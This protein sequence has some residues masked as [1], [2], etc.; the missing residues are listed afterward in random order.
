MQGLTRGTTCTHSTYSDLMLSIDN[1]RTHQPEVMSAHLMADAKTWVSCRCNLQRRSFGDHYILEPC[2]QWPIV[3]FT[4][5]NVQGS[6]PLPGPVHDQP[7]CLWY[8]L[9]TEFIEGTVDM[10]VLRIHA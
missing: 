9:S 1:D 7:T 5:G 6:K 2:S 4:E 10:S 3:V 8:G